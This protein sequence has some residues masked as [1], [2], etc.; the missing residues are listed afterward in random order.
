MS[1]P[2]HLWSGDWESESGAAGGRPAPLPR[3]ADREPAQFPQVDRA[4][5]PA[6]PPRVDRAAAPAVPP[7]ADRVGRRRRRRGV[8]G[9]RGAVL[10][11]ILAL[12]VA[13]AAYAVSS[14]D[15][16][17]LRNATAG[18]TP[19]LGVQLLSAP[20]G[21]LV[22]WVAPGS[23]AQAAGLRA[24][25]LITQVQGRPVVTPINVIDAV[26]ALSPGQTVQLGVQR[27]PHYFT[28]TAT[29]VAR[30]AGFPSP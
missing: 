19:W 29:L 21:V 7:R 20:A 25:D 11:A 15:N 13:G 6:R 9:L 16:T 30:P 22:G 26:Q 14:S 24:G 5:E 23:P 10:I 27:G 28:A 12:L 17:G 2:K 4:P 8:S 18:Q 1:G 3:P